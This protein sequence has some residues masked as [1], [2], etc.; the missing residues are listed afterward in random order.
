VTSR[1]TVFLW[2]QTA[3]MLV[4]VGGLGFGALP[5]LHSSPVRPEWVAARLMWLPLFAAILA[6]CQLIFGRF[7]HSR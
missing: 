6:G 3:M 2:H 4:T 7:E 1:M 5:G